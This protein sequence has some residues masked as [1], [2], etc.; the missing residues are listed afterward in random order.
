MNI[1]GLRRVEIRLKYV[2]DK[3][4]LRLISVQ[5]IINGRY[6]SA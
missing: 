2:D 4:N 5:I 3:L 1:S 6:I